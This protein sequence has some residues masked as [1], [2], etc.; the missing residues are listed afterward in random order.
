MNSGGAGGPPQA[1]PGGAQPF[2]FIQVASDPSVAPGRKA[3]VG[4]R[5]F[6]ADGT[7][8]WDKETT[9]DTGW[10]PVGTGGGGGLV[11]AVHPGPGITVAGTATD[12]IVNNAGVIS[13]NGQTGTITNPV[14]CNGI[15]TGA[16]QLASL[17]SL[18]Y[19]EG[20]LAWVSS[21]GSRFRL[22]AGALTVDSIT[23]VAASG[24]AGYQ[25]VR[26]NEVNQNWAARSAWAVDPQ[27]VLANDENSGIDDTVPLKTYAE[28][29]RRLFQAEIKQSTTV[30]C[31]SDAVA[32]DLAFFTCR[33]NGNRLT[34][35]SL[36]TTGITPLYSGTVSV[37]TPQSTGLAADDNELVD[38]T[39]PV[40]FTASGL[41]AVNLL[42]K[43][44]NGTAC[45]WFGA[46]DLGTKT[47]RT[48]VPTNATGN[49]ITN[50][51]AAD[52]YS[53]YKLPQLPAI[54]FI[55]NAFSRGVAFTEVAI[56]P[57]QSQEYDQWAIYTRCFFNSSTLTPSFNGFCSLSNCAFD[58]GAGSTSQV[59]GFNP[60]AKL[61]IMSVSW[62]LHRAANA[63]S[64]IIQAAGCLAM[65]GVT[66]QG[67][68]IEATSAA[69]LIVQGRISMY[70]TNGVWACLWA[71]YWSSILI[72]TSSAF[73][74]GGLAGTGNTGA[75]LAVNN[76]SNMAY[77]TGTAPTVAGA[78]SSGT[79]I[80]VGGSLSAV[81]ALPINKTLANDIGIFATN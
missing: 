17:A 59:V 56:Q 45:Y 12:P 22:Q 20:A 52:S 34:F 4:V 58:Y 33:S 7:A 57:G 21:V 79:P 1:T 6:L 70:D 76:W 13:E 27:N 67:V 32:G 77:V 74:T 9:A 62:G 8:A 53:V 68:T 61:G 46:K 43:R 30:T 39:I 51:V 19:S 35:T 10:V 50:P 2:P 24:K 28:L 16:T 55:A 31:Y 69:T 71:D 63:Q 5:A 75:L 36:T 40:S 60:G 26:V 23:V 14:F 49:A 18:A 47:L 38:N 41:L 64:Q 78:S 11:V 81:A 54:N 37:F 42:F 48:S 25:W 29:A 80:N 72:F 65:Q 15:L 3:A 66:C 73:G 44:T